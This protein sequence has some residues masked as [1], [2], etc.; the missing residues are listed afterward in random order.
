MGQGCAMRREEDA[1]RDQGD[2]FGDA[3][4]LAR[5]TLAGRRSPTERE[6]QSL[7][8]SSDRSWWH[9]QGRMSLWTILPP[10]SQTAAASPQFTQAFL[11]SAAWDWPFQ[12]ATPSVREKTPKSS[13]SSVSMQNF[14]RPFSGFA[15]RVMHRAPAAR[16]RAA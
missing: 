13:L 1:A 11:V 12:W 3:A 2:G 5:F 6:P 8:T 14:T 9:G 7:A 10:T 15:F 16:T 4:R